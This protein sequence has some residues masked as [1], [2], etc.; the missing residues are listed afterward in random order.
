MDRG[1]GEQEQWMEEWRK[2]VM[3][4][5]VETAGGD[6]IEMRSATKKENKT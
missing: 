1:S 5:G 6:G 2:R 3:D 4:G